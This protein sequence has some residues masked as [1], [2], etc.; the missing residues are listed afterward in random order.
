MSYI[1]GETLAMLHV[2][3]T[4]GSWI[5]RLLKL[6]QFGNVHATDP[7]PDRKTFCCT[8]DP[9]TWLPSMWAHCMRYDGY[10]NRPNFV[11]F[12]KTPFAE[13]ERLCFH[14]VVDSAEEFVDRYLARCPGH[15]SAAMAMYTSVCDFTLP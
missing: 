15:F 14:P 9:G 3:K 4:G 6:D 13:I 2:P 11:R 12:K 10:K 1:V 7:H 8:R 5:R